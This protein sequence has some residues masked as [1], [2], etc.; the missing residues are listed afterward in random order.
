MP[1]YPV[2]MVSSPYFDPRGYPSSILNV[3]NDKTQGKGTGAQ[4]TGFMASYPMAVNP[5]ANNWPSPVGL[6]QH[7]F[8]GTALPVGSTLSAPT[9]PIAGYQPSLGYQASPIIG[10]ALPTPVV[11]Y[12]AS[13]AF[14]GGYAA[15][16]VDAMG[17]PLPF[18]G[19]Q[20][21]TPVPQGGAAKGSGGGKKAAKK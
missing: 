3:P 9:P 2:S 20:S 5:V 17:F 19:S 12:H 1:S 8:V 15:L 6:A 14:I 7:P 11:G 13:P 21:N 18:P 10:S 4:A 16:P